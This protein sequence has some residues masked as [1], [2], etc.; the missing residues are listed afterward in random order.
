MTTPT[1]HDLVACAS[2]GNLDG[3]RQA[4]IQGVPVDARAANGYT[5]LHAAAERGEFRVAVL[6]YSVGAPTW[7]QLPTGETPLELAELNGRRDVAELLR[8][9][10]PLCP[11]CHARLINRFSRQCRQCGYD[12][13]NLARIFQRDYSKKQFPPEEIPLR[14]LTEKTTLAAIEA[15]IEERL[16]D[17]LSCQTGLPPSSDETILLTIRDFAADIQADE[18][19]WIYDNGPLAWEHMCGCHG[20]AIVR[21]GQIVRSRLLVMN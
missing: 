3:V 15:E 11:Y 8:H 19:L 16:K 17:G 7:L 21:N 5:A 6:L 10:S 1:A 20:V 9:P 4:L 14:W 12:W 18:E 13:H 2:A